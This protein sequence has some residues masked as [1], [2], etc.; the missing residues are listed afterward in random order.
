MLR[1]LLQALAIL[2][3]GPGVAFAL[4]AFGCE[5]GAAWAGAVCTMPPLRAFLGLTGA[6]WALVIGASWAWARWRAR[7]SAARGAP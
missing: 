6:A 7:A 1:R 3:L 4:I 2:H 5:D